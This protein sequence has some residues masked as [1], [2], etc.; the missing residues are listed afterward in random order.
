[1][2]SGT[3]NEKFP[4]RRSWA[5]PKLQKFLREKGL[6][7]EFVKECRKLSPNERYHKHLDSV[8]VFSDTDRGTH[9]WMNIHREYRL[10]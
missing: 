6:Y 2:K 4:N 5:Y 10:L 3:L 9:F 1:M 7:D 8:F